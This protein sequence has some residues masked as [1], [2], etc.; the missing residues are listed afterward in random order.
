MSLVASFFEWDA[1]SFLA[2]SAFSS[3]SFLI[4]P[5]TLFAKALLFLIL[6]LSFFFL[7]LGPSLLTFEPAYQCIHL[8][9]KLEISKNRSIFYDIPFQ[10]GSVPPPPPPLT[11]PT[12]LFLA[13]ASASESEP[14]TTSPT[15]SSVKEILGEECWCIWKRTSP[16]SLVPAGEWAPDACCSQPWQT[17]HNRIQYIFRLQN[18]VIL[19]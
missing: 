13:G 3:R 4:N 15:R 19:F 11:T 10:R 17:Y 9:I 6:L 14:R 12:W 1:S 7:I 8:L 18:H 5:M 2:H 16:L